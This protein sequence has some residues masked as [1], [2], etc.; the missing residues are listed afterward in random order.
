M[1]IPPRI[2]TSETQDIHLP[3]NSLE[4]NH[5]ED[6]PEDDSTIGQTLSVKR[7]LGK[8][9][10]PTLSPSLYRSRQD[11]TPLG[12]EV[13][14]NMMHTMYNTPVVKLSSETQDDLIEQLVL[15]LQNLADEKTFKC[16]TYDRYD[17]HEMGSYS[18]TYV[19]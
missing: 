8:Y 11:T 13:H 4:R 1:D 10:S 17:P 5:G 3:Q 16:R 14:T 7:G 15:L 19:R 12:E 6:N 9:R 2:E 18:R